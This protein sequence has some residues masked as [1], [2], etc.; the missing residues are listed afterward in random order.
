MYRK[1]L[2]WRNLGKLSRSSDGLH[3]L[4]GLDLDSP[5]FMILAIQ[6]WLGNG[7]VDNG[8]PLMREKT[9]QLGPYNEGDSQ[10]ISYPQWGIK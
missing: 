5:S 6:L 9:K 4:K 1:R 7:R 10:V 2:P 3:L 8:P